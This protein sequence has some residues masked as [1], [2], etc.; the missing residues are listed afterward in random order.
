MQFFFRVGEGFKKKSVHLIILKVSFKKMS[1]RISLAILGRFCG[2]KVVSIVSKN[3]NSKDYEFDKVLG[4]CVYYEDK[5]AHLTLNTTEIEKLLWEGAVPTI[6][7]NI[8]LSKAGLT[9]VH[10]NKLDELGLNMLG[11][12]RTWEVEVRD[13]RDKR[14]EVISGK[15]ARAKYAQ[16]EQDLPKLPKHTAPPITLPIYESNNVPKNVLES[17][18]KLTSIER[19][20]MLRSAV[21]KADSQTT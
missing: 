17:V 5:F 16:N 1:K 6:K 2:R 21:F 9:P 8:L 12:P 13:K 19:Q 11:D 3:A 7:A 20:R 10:Y 4:T 15:E 14:I 18:P